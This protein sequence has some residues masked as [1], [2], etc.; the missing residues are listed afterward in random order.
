MKW[1]EI[2]TDEIGQLDRNIPAILPIAAVE[3]H[4][5]HLPLATDSLIAD[6]LM[7]QLNKAIEDQILI[8]PTIRVGCSDHHMAFNGTLTTQHGHFNNYVQDIVNSVIT[9]GFDQ[10]ILFNCHG[11]NMGIAKV[12]YEQ[13]GYSQQHIRL[14]TVTWWQLVAPELTGLQ[15]S[16]AGGVGHAGEFETSL[17]LHF[18]PKQVRI[19]RIPDKRTNRNRWSWSDGDMIRGARAELYQRMDQKTLNGVYGDPWLA[20]AEKGAKIAD[21]VVNKL[22]TIVDDLQ[23][24]DSMNS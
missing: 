22:I 14:V 8:L 19:D 11:G 15:E 4:G 24:R 12:L 2:T 16:T 9:H 10:L 17:L 23:R 13:I 7:N 20:T 6:H 21:L 18:D 5:P 3:Q 1:E